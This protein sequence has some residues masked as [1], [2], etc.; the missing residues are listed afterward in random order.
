LRRTSSTGKLPRFSQEDGEEPAEVYSQPFTPRSEPRGRSRGRGHRGSGRGSGRGER[1]KPN[2]DEDMPQVVDPSPKPSRSHSRSVDPRTEGWKPNE[3]SLQVPPKVVLHP[4]DSTVE[5]NGERGTVVDH[6]PT[7]TRMLVK[8]PSCTNAVPLQL[9]DVKLVENPEGSKQSTENVDIIEEDDA[10]TDDDASTDDEDTQEPA[11]QGKIMGFMLKIKDNVVA[12]HISLDSF[13][14]GRT[15]NNT[16]FALQ[17]FVDID[18]KSI[19]RRHAEISFSK[20]AG[21]FTLKGLTAKAVYP[22]SDRVLKARDVIEICGVQI[23]F[24]VICAKTG[25]TQAPPSD[26]TITN[27]DSSTSASS[28]VQSVATPPP[29][30]PTTTTTTTVPK[31]L[32]GSSSVGSGLPR[33]DGNAAAPNTDKPTGS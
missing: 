2:C 25:S 23:H 4:I 26:G 17:P 33:L 13:V 12:E 5:W 22:I 3:L 21:T 24:Q 30:P 16:N 6:T 7:K 18:T 27:T 20:D 14:I 19:S 31:P 29:P 10:G 11:N 9:G 1:R 32:S 28:G 15:A 8:V